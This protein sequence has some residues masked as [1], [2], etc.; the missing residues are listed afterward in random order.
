MEEARIAVTDQDKILTLTMGLLNVYNPVI[1]NFN[2][3]PANQLTYDNV[4]TH[5]LNEETRQ[6]SKTSA[7]PRSTHTKAE[8]GDEAL[9]TMPTLCG[10][11]PR[12]DITCYFCDAKGHFK[13]ECQE[14]EK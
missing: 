8:D 13:S 6:A 1:I 3:T 11:C 12:A 9:A 5:L 2:S 7:A 14:K 4:I 10:S